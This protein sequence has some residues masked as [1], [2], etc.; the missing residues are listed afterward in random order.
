MRKNKLIMLQLVV[1][2]MLICTSVYA[3]STTI[4]LTPSETKVDP[5]STVSVTLSLKDVDSSKKV[6]SVEGYINYD[7]KV[8]E[9]I[10]VKSIEQSKNNT[11][12]IGDEELPVEDVTSGD[13]EASESYVAFNGAPSSDNQTKIVIDFKDGISEDVDLLK[14]NFKVKDSATAGEIKDAIS[15]SMFQIT[16]G[17]SSA[18][19]IT[20]S[21]TLTVNSVEKP[22]D[23]NGENKD[24][25][26]KWKENTS[27]SKSAT[28]TEDGYKFYEC[29][30]EGCTETKKETVKATGH[31]FGDWKVTK[32][33]T[34]KAEGEKQRECSVC[35]TVEKQTI[36]KKTAND[37]KNENKNEN[38]NTNKNTNV[39]TN[40]S[41]L[42]G[43]KLPAT[44][45]RVVIVPAVLLIILAYV[46]YNR[47][48]KFK[49][50]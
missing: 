48:L 20:K 37:D 32:E 23:G 1:V 44:G 25:E 27:K 18:E 47:Y 16:D 33:A 30:E 13:V 29:T 15:Y 26:H 24:H 43:T 6:K 39:N 11:V 17:S 34:T 21:I 50:I 4:E 46:S 14:V 38:K 35:K 5:G 2:F 45:A 40:D 49:D 36:A 22:D 10:T 19:E 41:T 7:T 8:I 42:A 3:A 28:C 31:K 12:K 9:P